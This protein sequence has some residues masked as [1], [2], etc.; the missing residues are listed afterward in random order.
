MTA[1]TTPS[2]DPPDGVEVVVADEPEGC[3]GKVNA[4]ALGME[5]AEHDRF[6]RTD[7]DFERDDDWLDRRQP[8]RSATWARMTVRSAR[9]RCSA[10]VPGAQSSAV[11]TSATFASRG[12]R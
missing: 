7:D 11:A 3:S 10:A 5:R 4:M 9:R 2:R 6:V 12:S 8:R 1:R